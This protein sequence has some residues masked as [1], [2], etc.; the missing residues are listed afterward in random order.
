MKNKTLLM[1]IAIA[2]LACSCDIEA[3]HQKAKTEALLEN[4]CPGKD[5][6]ITDMTP[7]QV[8]LFSEQAS[9]IADTYTGLCSVER[10]EA[11]RLA[12]LL[13]EARNGCDP[14]AESLE[15]DLRRCEE[16]YSTYHQALSSIINYQEKEL[17]NRPDRIA[18]KEKQFFYRIKE[19]KEQRYDSIIVRFDYAGNLVG[20]R[21]PNEGWTVRRHFFQIPGDY[22]AL[23]VCREPAK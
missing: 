19:G 11:E 22:D 2:A 21:K 3:S 20:Y 17:K 13:E 5:I 9:L 15:E 4:I 16:R 12:L 18:A 23:L 7:Y 8:E 6:K 14:F 10:K 1:T